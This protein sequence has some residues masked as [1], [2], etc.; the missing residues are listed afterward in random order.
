[1]PTIAVAK[2]PDYGEAMPAYTKTVKIPGRSAQDLY[3]KISRDIDQMVEKW[4]VAGKMELSRDPG[5]RQL[6]LKS[7]MVTATLT[8]GEENMVLDGKLSLLAAPF[9]S[10]IDEQIDRWISKNFPV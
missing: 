6:H 9:R 10:K 4:G 2:H 8:C 3:E 5:K 7:S 1:M